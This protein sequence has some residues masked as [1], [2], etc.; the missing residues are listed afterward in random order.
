M[1]ELEIIL[2]RDPY[3]SFSSE[4]LLAIEDYCSDIRVKEISYPKI[5][6]RPIINL[7]K[8]SKIKPKRR[9]KNTII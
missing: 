5:K 3:N 7:M 8:Q 6:H 4:L 9:C 2:R 1:S